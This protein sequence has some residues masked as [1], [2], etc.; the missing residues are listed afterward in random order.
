[1]PKAK[2]RTARVTA[3]QAIGTSQPRM[4]EVLPNATPRPL[5]QYKERELW[6]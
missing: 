5:S 6:G 2:T 3:M 1:L 4:P